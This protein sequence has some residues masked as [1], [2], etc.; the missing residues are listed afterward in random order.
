MQ[1]RHHGKVCKCTDIQLAPPNELPAAFQFMEHIAQCH[2]LM[3][4]RQFTVVLVKLS[5]FTKNN[6]SLSKISLLL[7]QLW[8]KKLIRF[9][10]KYR[11]FL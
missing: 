9:E 4:I 8:L 10:L 5:H 7:L 6:V 3:Y 2:L 1:C 11:V